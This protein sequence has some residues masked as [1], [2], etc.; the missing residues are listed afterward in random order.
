MARTMTILGAALVLIAL[1]TAAVGADFV[2]PKLPPGSELSATG[3]NPYF[4]LKPG[5]QCFYKSADGDL[6]IT[7]LNETKVVDG[8]VT[9]I[10]EERENGNGKLVEVSRNYFAISKKDKTIYYFGE[11]VDMYNSKGKITGHGGSW[12][13]G[14]KGAKP[15]VQMPGTVKVGMKYYQEVAPKVAMDRAEVM[16]LTETLKLP[17]GDT[18]NV[19]KTF[20]TSAVEPGAKEYKYYARGIGLVKDEDMLL[21]RHGFVK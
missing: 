13:A 3:A 4:I 1:C 20:E 19:M 15:G 11:D 6:T 7:V 16:S 21:T 2:V 17:V 12:L 14:V 9:R 10:I 8:V 5:Y 18:K